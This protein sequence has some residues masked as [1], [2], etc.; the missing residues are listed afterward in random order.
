MMLDGL[1]DDK[2]I[3]LAGQGDEAAF[4]LLYERH[5][6]GV[7]RFAYRMCGAVA[8]AE[9]ITQECFLS[10]IR[11][12]GQFDSSLS[13]LRTYLLAAVRNQTLKR[14]RHLNREVNDAAIDALGEEE[15]VSPGFSPLGQMLE[16]EIAEVVSQAVIA[17]PPLQREVLILFEYEE[18]SLTEIAAIADADVGAVKA[19]LHRAR[20]N[21]RKMLAPYVKNG[22]LMTAARR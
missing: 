1:T 22:E 14:F 18:L 17:L 2:L 10:L 20:E 13:S 3:E 5:R 19:R 12:P 11:R 9:D 16:A 15:L 8:E 6:D 4:R 7:F 21:L